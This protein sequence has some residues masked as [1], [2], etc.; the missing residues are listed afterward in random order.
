MSRHRLSIHIPKKW[1]SKGDY[2]N[3]DIQNA[4]Y[5]NPRITGIFG[6]DVMLGSFISRTMPIFIGVFLLNYEILKDKNIKYFV[7]Q[8]L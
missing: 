8:K 5:N 6:P 2:Q 3:A 1:F 4:V 7:G